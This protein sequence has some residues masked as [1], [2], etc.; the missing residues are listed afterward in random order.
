MGGCE[1]ICGEVQADGTEDSSVNTHN[2]LHVDTDFQGLRDDQSCQSVAALSSY[3]VKAAKYLVKTTLDHSYIL[4][5]IRRESS[6]DL[7]KNVIKRILTSEL[8]S[9][10][11]AN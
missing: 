5:N 4:H 2:P 6:K 9:K 1:A 3:H 7:L 11:R 8:F 10:L